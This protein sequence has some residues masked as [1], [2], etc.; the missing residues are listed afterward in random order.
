MYNHFHMIHSLILE[1]FIYKNNQ[2]KS[3]LKN[4]LFWLIYIG[5]IFL[6]SVFFQA[7]QM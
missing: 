4:Y 5:L 6:T 1:N 3:L 7:I 2:F